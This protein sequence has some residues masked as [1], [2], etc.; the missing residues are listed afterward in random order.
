MEDAV[1]RFAAYLRRRYGDRSTPKHYLN[2]LQQVCK[3]LGDTPLSAATAA[4]IDHFVAQ[5][6]TAGLRPRTINR[7]LAAV[8]AFF[9]FLALEDPTTAPLNPVVWRRQGVKQGEQLPRDLSD[10]LTQQ[11]FAIIDDPRDLAM[12]GLML[13][14]GLRVGEVAA[15]DLQDLELTD[16]P[17]RLSQL[18]VCGKGRKERYAW[19][20]PYWEEV[21][22]AWLAQRPT[23]DCQALFV[24]QHGRRLSVA[25]I[26]YRLQRY[27]Q[28]AGVS[29][30]CHQLRHTFARRLA[31][32]GLPV[33]ILARLLGHNQVTTT[34]IYT[35]GADMQLQQAFAQAM[36]GLEQSAALIL[37][38]A[39]AAALP[40]PARQ[41]PPANTDDLYASYQHLVP[42]PAW[43]RPVLQAYLL[44]RWRDW[45]P[46]LA[47]KHAQRLARRLWRIWDGLLTETPIHTWAELSRS[48]VEAWLTT[49][50]ATGIA[51]TTQITELN[52][53]FAC[54]HFATDH[55]CAIDPQIFRIPYP[56]R[57]Q[58]LPRY[59][60]EADYDKLE[61]TVLTATA[62]ATPDMRRDRAWF[63]TLAH[64]GVRRAELLNL[65]LADLDLQA[66]RLTVR[67]GK[68]TR[69]RVVYLTA[70]LRL[71]LQSYLAQ[72]PQTTDDHLWLTAEGPLRETYVYHRL[73]Q[74]GK[75][76]GVQVSPH[77]LRHT[78]ATRLLNQGL[79]LEAI[80]KLLGH[81]T[82]AMTQRY[83]CL[84][85]A[86]VCQQFQTAMEQ[87]EGIAVSSW[88]QSEH[89]HLGKV[90]TAIET[91]SV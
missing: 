43:L 31:E 78:L 75:V 60:P 26:E 81:K 89:I 68:G 9:A 4:D 15:L 17:G 20:T 23:G 91:D 57:P 86:T 21:L 84:Y 7:R 44:Q 49:R 35:A 87:L 40:T 12:F 61:Q 13:G 82:L 32:Q 52:D 22:Q 33:E 67:G 59:L 5:Q 54:L 39:E 41:E 55:G 3:T 62:A 14:A 53:V 6:V 71:A 73:R 11:L 42:L 27:A 24:N 36:H 46:H 63:F 88:P 74:W 90:L 45:Q 72:R 79:T 2:D 25:G 64:T 19:L 51:L 56:A 65:R 76:C 30:H 77:R 83:A 48:T 66:G 80:R 47:A 28:R 8:C 1:E 34:Q 58:P 10:H 29:V 85:D 70:T 18:R 37:P 69:D 16:T 38:T 50:Q